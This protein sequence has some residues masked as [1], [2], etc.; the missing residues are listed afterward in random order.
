MEFRIIISGAGGQGVISAGEFL[1]E[2]LF[3]EGYEVVTTRS[4]GAEARGGS[5]RSEVIV[6][7][8]EIHALEIHEAN[9]IIAMSMPAYRSFIGRAGKEALILVE[10]QLLAELADK[11]LRNDVHLVEIPANE[12]AVA[13]GNPV[14]ANMVFLGALIKKIGL[15]TPEKLEETVKKLIR[16][17]LQE[18]NIK[19]V[20]AGY[21]MI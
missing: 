20:R 16:P 3:R 5:A 4:Y 10:K 15:L 12:T 1:S 21:S 19:A 2:A 7:D 18:I 6:S 17:A 13:L 14:V 11:D 8:E 9:V